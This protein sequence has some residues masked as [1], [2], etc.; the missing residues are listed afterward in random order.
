MESAMKRLRRQNESQAQH[1]GRQAKEIA[2][3]K[4]EVAKLAKR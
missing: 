2:S 4:R 1:N 3:L